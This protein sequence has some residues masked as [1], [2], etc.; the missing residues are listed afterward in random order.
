VSSGIATLV[1][2]GAGA[3][4]G[5]IPF[6][7]IIARLTTGADVRRVGSGNI[8]ATNVLRASGLVPALLT[9]ICDAGKGAASVFLARAL[10]HASLAPVAAG[11]AAGSG[12]TLDDWAGFAA[13]AG[14]IFSPWLGFRGGK[15]VAT[16]AGALAVLSPPVALAAIGVFLLSVLIFR[17]VSLGS[18][19]ACLAAMILAAGPFRSVAP[20]FPVVLAIGALIIVRHAANIARIVRGTEPRI[21][22]GTK[23]REP[24]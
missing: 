17:I 18:I 23:S 12:S 21:G 20:S 14:H 13:V 5:S 16:A 6:G 19:L 8:G 4:L 10:V 2:I 11:T 7:L 15:G 22:T 1:A 24:S 9:L 3:L